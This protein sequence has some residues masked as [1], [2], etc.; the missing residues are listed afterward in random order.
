MEIMNYTTVRKNLSHVIKT[1]CENHDHLF[2][3]TKHEGVTGVLISLQEWNSIQET[4]FLMRGK[5]GLRLL[6]SIAD[7]KAGVGLVEVE[8]DEKIGGY[9]AVKGASE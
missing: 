9:V 4:A 2:I 6:K 1:V 8:F 7:I 3:T 5:N